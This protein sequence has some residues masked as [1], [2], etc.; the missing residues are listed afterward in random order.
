MEA[1]AYMWPRLRGRLQMSPF[2]A[3]PLAPCHSVSLSRKQSHPNLKWL[4]RLEGWKETRGVR[5]TSPT[6]VITGRLAGT[7]VTGSEDPQEAQGQH[8][9]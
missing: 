8:C 6:P 4:Q 5:L 3:P 7:T 9:P 1:A 2:P